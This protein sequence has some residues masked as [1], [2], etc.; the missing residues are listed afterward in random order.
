MVDRQVRDLDDGGSVLRV[1]AA[2]TH[3]GIRSQKLPEWFR[4]LIASRTAGKGPTDRIF[5]HDRIWLLKQVKRICKLAGVPEV[6]T[7][8]LRGT[9]ADLSLQAHVTALAVSQALG[10]T[11]TDVTFG[12]Y[13][14]RKIVDE[15]EQA[16]VLS[17]LAPTVPAAETELPNPGFPR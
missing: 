10:R 4:P 9:R 3:A 14:D 6:S 12:L 2:K 16:L 11:S 5:E 8:G 1:P 15:H 17:V 7:H 13:A